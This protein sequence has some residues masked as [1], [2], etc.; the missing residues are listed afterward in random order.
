MVWTVAWRMSR[1]ISARA[2]ATRWST[3]IESGPRTSMTVALLLA[4]STNT[5]RRRQHRRGCRRVGAVG[6]V[7]A[8]SASRADNASSPDKRPPDVG[9]DRRPVGVAG[10]V[11][12]VRNSDA[13]MPCSSLWARAPT[14]SMPCSASTPASRANVPGRSR[15]DDDDPRPIDHRPL[16]RLRPSAP[17]R[18]PSGMA[19][20][21]R[22]RRRRR[23]ATPSTHA[24]PL[25]QLLDE[26]G[27][28]RA[29]RR[30]ARLPASRPRSARAAGRGTS[31][32]PTASATTSI[33]AGSS[34]SR[35]VAMSGNSRWWR[36]N[37]TS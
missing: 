37:P 14:T 6:S 15:V 12:A 13:A 34:R 32:L 3:P 4:S 21:A 2:L 29:P 7:R 26:L 10:A 18:R 19:I 20:G 28:P 36:T 33:V 1:P 16:S 35:R 22:V 24:H 27:L 25:D 8:R 9:R 17:G 23:R 11:S 5:H 30:R 31:T